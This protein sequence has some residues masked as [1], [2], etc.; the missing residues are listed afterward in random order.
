MKSKSKALSASTVEKLLVVGVLLLIVTLVFIIYV[1]N[2]FLAEKAREADHA[3]TDAKIS[4]TDL[5]NMKR[6]GIKLDQ[7]KTTVERTR[8]II[9]ESKLYLYQ[10]EIVNDFQTYASGARVEKIIGF[11][12]AQNSSTTTTTTASKPASSGSAAPAAAGAGGTVPASA[13]PKGV[14]SIQTTINFGETN[15]QSMLKFIKFIEQ[16]VTRMQ[17]TDL[18]LSPKAEDANI[19]SN[20]TMIIQVYT[21]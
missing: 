2:G 6:A 18:T 13:Q 10:N 8:K 15:Y 16:N 5:E 7:E 14:H 1:M 19:L 3:Q 12:F 17:I 4:D 11:T 9:A 20:P 21:R